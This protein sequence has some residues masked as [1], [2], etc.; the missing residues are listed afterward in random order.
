MKK[1]ILAGLLFSL[2][3]IG[4]AKDKYSDYYFNVVKKD[5]A[6][7]N[8]VA[9]YV[10]EASS[11]GNYK[12]LM[13]G[14]QDEG[15]KWNISGKTY[16]KYTICEAHNC[17]DNS[18]IILYNVESKKVAGVMF[19]GCSA[20]GFGALDKEMVFNIAQE[21]GTDLNLNRCK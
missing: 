10:D 17:F 21:L 15:Q 9:N 7:N 11:K 2:T 3:S 18:A 12:V 4:F 5:K 20:K 16:Y 1:I 6:L 19:D 14:P 8:Q 13:N